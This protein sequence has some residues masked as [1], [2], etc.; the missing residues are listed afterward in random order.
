VVFQ[1]IH[2][3]FTP[4]GLRVHRHRVS[5]A[6][7]SKWGQMGILKHNSK[8]VTGAILATLIGCAPADDVT[9]FNLNPTPE[10]LARGYLPILPVSFFDMEAFTPVDTKN[11]AARAARLRRKIRALSR[12]VISTRDRARLEAAIA[13]R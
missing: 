10:S 2:L 8:Y 3:R 11:L 5:K 1:W 4:C 7:K 6:M 12:P 13:R 9:R